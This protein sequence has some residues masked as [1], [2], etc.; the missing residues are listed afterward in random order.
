MD[1]KKIILISLMLL[2][3]SLG[4]VSA[5]DLNQTYMAEASC[6]DSLESMDIQVSENLGASAGTFADLQGE[7]NNA[8][9][10]SVLILTRDYNGDGRRIV[11]I[12]KDLTIDGQGHTI[13]CMRVDSCSAFTSNQG[14]ITLKN[15]KITRGHDDDSI[16]EGGAI[17]ITGSAQYTIENCVF[18]DNWADDY[19]GAIY[20]AVDKPLT[21]IHSTFKSN[22]AD[23]YAGGAIWSKGSVSIKN[24]V[25]DSCRAATDGG[26]VYSENV[27]DVDSCTFLSNRA[28]SVSHDSHGGA[29][30]SKSK[31]NIFN[32][33]FDDNY[34]FD[35]GGAIYAYSVYINDLENTQTFFINNRVIDDQGGAI[36][37]YG[38]VYIRNVLFIKNK[39]QTDGGAV[40]CENDIAAV[41]CIFESNTAN[42]AIVSCL[43]GALCSSSSVSVN[44]CI[45]NNSYADSEGG[46]IHGFDV[47]VD[48]ST[49]TNNFAQ[50]DGGAI[51]ARN[52][53]INTNQAS[54][55]PFNTFFENNKVDN[56]EGGAIYTGYLEV[57]NTVFSKNR[58]NEEGGAVK[59]LG[60]AIVK[61][62]LFESNRVDD[63]VFDTYGGAICANTIHVYNSTFKD[64]Y[65][66]D[67]GGAIRAYEIN[68]NEN[69]DGTESYNTFFINN[70]AGEDKGGAIYTLGKNIN[71]VNVVFS[72][73]SA[74]VDGGAVCAGK[75]NANHCLFESNEANGAK[76]TPCWGGAVCVDEDAYVKNC[77]FNSNYA[78]NN[79]GALYSKDDLT[80]D[81]CT[82][83]YNKARIDGGAVWSDTLTLKQTPSYFID[84]VAVYS[85]GGA[86]WVNKFNDDVKYA[87][88]VHNRACEKDGTD[89]GGAIYIDNSNTVTF[90]QCVF[91]N[92]WCSDEGGA[93]YLDTQDSHLTLINNIFIG[94]SAGDK[95]YS[96]YNCGY[97]DKIENN[98]WGDNN[99]SKE[100]SQVVEW[101]K[102]SSDEGHTD[103]N[104]LSLGLTLSKSDCLMNQVVKAT[105]CFYS[106]NGVLFNGEMYNAA[107]SISAN[108]NTKM[109]NKKNNPSTVSVDITPEKE[110]IY[111]ITANL[112]GKTVS[113]T[114]N[115][116][117]FKITAPDVTTDY[118]VSKAFGI[119]LDGDKSLTANKEIKVTMDSDVYNVRTDE[120]GDVSFYFNKYNIAVGEHVISIDIH[121]INQKS[122][123][124]IK[125]GI[126]IVAPNEITLINNVSRLFK[127]NLEGHNDLIANQTVY[128]V[129][130]DVNYE[131]LTDERGYGSLNTT[132]TDLGTH[133]FVTSIY[134][135]AK[136]GVM[137][138][139]NLEDVEI[140][141]N[142]LTM[143]YGGDDECLVGA[144]ESATGFSI[145]NLDL[146][147]E[148]GN[149][150]LS[151]ET[152]N[153]GTASFAPKLAVGYHNY[154]AVLLTKTATAKIKVLSTVYANNVIKIFKN[155]TQFEATFR[156]SQ[157]NFLKEGSEVEFE[158]NGVTYTRTVI[159]DQGKAIL[160][161]NLN[162]GTY[163][164]VS[165]NLVSHESVTNTILILS[166]V[167]NNENLVKY[168]R[169]STQF[170]VKTLGNDGNIKT[171]EI[172]KFTVNGVTYERVSDENGV[173]TLN[174]NLEPGEYEILTEYGGN[175][176]VN[177][178]TVKSIFEPQL[179][180]YNGDTYT[181][182]LLD[183]Q[184]NP[185]ANQL[186]KFNID[187]V[188]YQAKTD[189]SGFANL[190]LNLMKGTYIITSIFG[191]LCASETI[192]VNGGG[193]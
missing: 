57:V 20:N 39:A 77:I 48:N 24:S 8:P 131:V 160:N 109:N 166:K 53:Y 148:C 169:N 73:N 184:G 13:D 193:R 88:F 117:Y 43:G 163:Y 185:Y 93:I 133:S 176:E 173:A 7:I 29:I 19:G 150:R 132:L 81:N 30:F 119:H 188:I 45:F 149:L 103:S 79:G 191:D 42:G 180:S 174:I 66:E 168:Y 113:K 51:D 145:V 25:F 167:A 54:N 130:D 84:N 107:V 32:S 122:T 139:M 172:V 112:Y 62:C 102:L 9:A 106:S 52:L 37:A 28:Y 164:I 87:T 153:S 127:F 34:A 89:D 161:I 116:Q 192:T 99:P 91:V 55:L 124:F 10:G 190:K 96:V 38:A 64:N 23:D 137:N 144:F 22:T 159:N 47:T 147:V 183:G 104:P 86:I 67:Y 68:I 76:S 178:I 3:L 1:F 158:I 72:G 179:N 175:Y 60:D 101:H 136:N 94:N 114:L 58:A 151:L 170:S 78:E 90:S 162:P 189:E 140:Y 50:H 186:V 143:Y 26:A 17:F 177:N 49:F 74:L 2:I 41:S 171:G 83:A 44:N 157:G 14:F 21:I 85:Q 80:I 71:L 182:K 123:L 100:N 69:Q 15:L 146:A 35:Y 98:Y 115:I 12:D 36:Y 5:A 6:D 61:H 138:V 108:P 4:A 141:A 142:D 156:D 105:Q 82:F 152:D 40:Y 154:A 125:S 97:Y 111:T 46:A 59:C 128:I 126:N 65:A 92:N 95:G 129:L 155:E 75:I 118:D 120:N 135:V 56:L 165:T 31:V 134:D 33:T 18:E 121:D 187:G 27:V 16:Y 11:H 110:G 70:V 63:S 181:V